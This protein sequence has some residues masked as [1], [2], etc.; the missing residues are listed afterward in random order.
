MSATETEI[1]NCLGQVKLLAWRQYR[2]CKAI[3]QEDLESIGR[4]ALVDAA[5]RADGR[6]NLRSFAE[7]RIR[8]AMVDA[9][10]TAPLVHR[11]G[12][13]IEPTVELDW[14]IPDE[15]Y[16]TEA[17]TAQAET[18]ERA[19]DKLSP[20]EKQ[21][22]RLL[23]EGYTQAEAAGILGLHPSRVNQLV[24]VI[25]EKLAYLRPETRKA[26]A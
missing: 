23:A 6:G 12:H 18:V 14:D 9:L 20:R 26:A 11:R 25:R 7:F 19:L 24:A 22:V 15:R 21:I 13:Y 2:R 10:R 1:L 3:P 17:R 16:D 4:L 5:R 8:G